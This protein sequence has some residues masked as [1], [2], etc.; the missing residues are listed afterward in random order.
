MKKYEIRLFIRMFHI[1]KNL[2][3]TDVMLQINKIWRSD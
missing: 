3:K 2:F 1:R